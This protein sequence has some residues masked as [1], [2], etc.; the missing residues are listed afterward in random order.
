MGHDLGVQWCPDG[1]KQCLQFLPCTCRSTIYLQQP[2][3]KVSVNHEIKSKQLETLVC[4][5][6]SPYSLQNKKDY[7]YFMNN[8]FDKGGARNISHLTNVHP[9]AKSQ[10]TKLAC[11]HFALLVCIDYTVHTTHEI[12]VIVIRLFLSTT[13]YLWM[14]LYMPSSAFVRCLIGNI[15]DH[16]LELV[17]R[18]LREIFEFLIQILIKTCKHIFILWDI[19]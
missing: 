8:E 7:I 6:V 14:C 9:S 13:L 4:K 17:L 12:F 5:I 2:N 1:L 3:F 16:A 19:P 11:E 15:T 10:F 18:F